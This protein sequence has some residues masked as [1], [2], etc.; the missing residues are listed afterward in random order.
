MYIWL[1]WKNSILC[2]CIHNTILDKRNISAIPFGSYSYSLH[3]GKDIN[4]SVC[5]R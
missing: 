4:Y 5:Y 1:E 3:S 2:I